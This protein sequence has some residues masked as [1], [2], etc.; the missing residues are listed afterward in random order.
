MNNKIMQAKAGLQKMA[1]V[2]KI[3]IA[4]ILGRLLSIEDFQD[5]RDF[6]FYKRKHK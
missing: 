4:R 1:I 3:T 6:F 2:I 5:K